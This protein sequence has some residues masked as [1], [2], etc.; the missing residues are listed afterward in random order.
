MSDSETKKVTNFG[1][2]SPISV[3]TLESNIRYH[4]QI[5]QSLLEIRWREDKN[6]F[7]PFP[8]PGTILCPL[9]QTLSI[10]SDNSIWLW[11][12]QFGSGWLHPIFFWCNIRFSENLQFWWWP[13]FSKSR[14]KYMCEVRYIQFVLVKIKLYCKRT[15]FH[16]LLCDILRAKIKISE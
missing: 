7:Q 3:E 16:V 4:D 15:N 5:D 9:F 2:P 13:T 11:L 14:S 10:F 12:W 6:N 1:E 8:L